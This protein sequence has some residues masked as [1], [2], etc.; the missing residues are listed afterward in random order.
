MSAQKISLRLCWML[1]LL[2]ILCFAGSDSYGQQATIFQKLLN[3]ASNEIVEGK[4]C[5]VSDASV[6]NAE[7]RAKMEAD[8]P[9]KN[10]VSLKINESSTRYF[11]DS[12]T[13]KVLVRIVSKDANGLIDSVDKEFKVNYQLKDK[14]QSVSSYITEGKR[15]VTARILSVTAPSATWVLYVIQLENKMEIRPLF[16]FSYDNDVVTTL[17]YPASLTGAVDQL[18]VT[19]PAVTGIDVYDVEWTYV[20]SSA[21]ALKKKNNA[22]DADLIFTNNASRVTVSATSYKIPLLY[23]GKGMLFFRVRPVQL[24]A[25]SGRLEGKWSSTDTK[26]LGAFAFEGHETG[27]NWQATTSFAEEGKRKTVVQYFDGSLRSRQVVTKDNTSDTTIIGE[28]FYD[29]QGRAVIQVLP[30]PSLDRVI[31]FTR[32]FNMGLNGEYDKDKYDLLTSP[33]Y[34]CNAKAEPMAKTSGSSRYYSPD[35]AAKNQGNNKFLPDASLYPFSQ[36]EY[37]PDNTGKISRQGGVGPDYQLGSGHETK[38]YYGGSPDKNELYALFGTDVGDAAHYV[39]NMVRD[40]NGQY[41]ISYLDMRGHVIATALAGNVPDS[42]KLQPLI[43][44]VSE[45]AVETIGGPSG[46]TIKGLSMES[47]KVLHVT[48]PGSYNFSYKLDPDTLRMLNYDQSASCY[49]CLYDLEITITDDCNNQKL[50]GAPFKRIR[51]NFSLENNQGLNA[52]CSKGAEKFIEEF[53][54]NLDEGSYVVT[55]KL[56]VSQYALDYYR[57]SVFVKK[58]AFKTIEELAKEERTLQITGECIPDC[59]SC[60]QQLGEWNDFRAS[61]LQKAGVELSDTAAHRGEAWVAWKEA[62][63]RC[64]RLC[65]VITEAD[66]LHNAMVADMTP[67]SGQYA[68]IN[69]IDDPYSIFYIDTIAQT[70]PIYKN[71]ALYYT[72]QEGSADKVYDEESETWVTPHDLNV[73]QFAAKFNK[74]WAETLL[75]YHPEYCKLL[76]YEKNRASLAWN[77]KAET[78]DTYQEAFDSGYLNPSGYIS[79]E[80]SRFPIVDK[81]RDPLSDALKVKVNSKIAAYMKDNEGYNISLW[82]MATIAVMANADKDNA[83]KKYRSPGSAFDASMCAGD[84]DM[85]WRIYRQ[86]Y[87]QLKNDYIQQMLID[88]NC[89]GKPAAKDLSDKGYTVH[90]NTAA[91]ALS[92]SGMGDLLSTNNP[93]QSATVLKAA[94]AQEYENNCRAYASM[95]MRQM[96]PCSRYDQVRTEIIEELVKVC[97]KGADQNHTMGSRNI[98]P[99]S[100]NTY[101]SFEDV[102]KEYN[103]RL[104]IAEGDLQ[105]NADVFTAPMPFDK[106]GAYSQ[107]SYTRPDECVRAKLANYQYQYNQNKKVGESFSTYLARTT[108]TYISDVDLTTFIDICNN[109]ASTC[110]YAEKTVSIPPVFQCYTGDVC[111]PCEKVNDLYTLFTAKYPAITPVIGVEVDSIQDVKNRLFENFMNSRLGFSKQAWEY[112]QFM[113][114]CKGGDLDFGVVKRFTI[115]GSK[116][117]VIKSVFTTDDNAFIMAG[118]T[119]SPADDMNAF[120]AKTDKNGKVLWAKDYGGTGK[121]YFSKVIKGVDGGLAAIGTTSSFN[122]GGWA[123]SSSGTVRSATEAW[124]VKLDENGDVVW[125]KTMSY[126]STGEK[127]VDITTVK[128]TDEDGYAIVGEYQSADTIGNTLVARLK[129]N[130]DPIWIKQ[131][132]SNFSDYGGRIAQDGDTI[133]VAASSIKANPYWFLGNNSMVALYRFLTSNGD[134][135]GFSIYD[136][137]NINSTLRSLDVMPNGYRITSLN[138]ID[139]VHK[140]NRPG[141]S[142]LKVDKTGYFKSVESYGRY[143][144]DDET[145]SEFSATVLPNKDL[146]IVKSTSM[147]SNDLRFQTLTSTGRDYSKSLNI[148]GNEVSGY[149]LQN[150]D[151]SFALVGNSTTPAA[152]P[153]FVRLDDSFHAACLDSTVY[154]GY[155]GTFVG[156]NQFATP[157]V[158]AMLTGGMRTISVIANNRSVGESLAYC[159]NAKSESRMLCGRSE[160]VFPEAVIPQYTNCTDSTF[161]AVNVA[162]ERY[163]IIRD[164][165]Y[166]KFD[167]AYLAKCMTAIQYEDF[168]V[169]HNANEYHYTLYYYDQ[170][171]NLVQTIAPNDVKPNRDPAWLKEVHRL[172]ETNGAAKRPDHVK[173][174]RYRYNSLN[175]VVAQ[176]SPDAGSSRFWYDRLGR[177]TL[178]Q[179]AEQI[180]YNKYSYT[181]YDAIGRITEVGQLASAELMNDN[182]SR[183]DVELKGWLTRSANSREQVTRTVY[184]LPYIPTEYDFKP[185]NLR[186]RVS[187]SAVYDTYADLTTNSYNNATYYSYDVHGNVDTLLQNYNNDLMKG[188]AS[189]FKKI[190][191]RYDLVSGKVNHVAYQ[192]GQIDAFY[193]RYSYDAENRLVNVETSRDSVNWDND[194]RYSYYSHGPLSRVVLGQQQVQG[195]D[196]AY[197]LQGWIKAVNPGL[198]LTGGNGETCSDGSA[199]NDLI[200]NARVPNGP[201]VYKARVTISFEDGFDSNSEDMDALIDANATLCNS[202]ATNLI[203]TDGTSTTTPAKDEFS[204]V[205]HYN[206]TDYKPLVAGL[207][208]LTVPGQLGDEYRPLYNGNISGMGV[209]VSKLDKPLWYNYKYDQLN[210][211]VQMDAWKSASGNWNTL[212]KGRSNNVEN[213][214]HEGITYDAN[215]N[216]ISYDRNGFAKATGVPAMDRLAYHYV[217]GKNRLDHIDD[218]APDTAYTTDIEGQ[219]AGYYTYDSIGNLTHEGGS[220]ITWNVYGKIVS[221]KKEDNVLIRYSYD[222]FGNRICKAVGN[223]VTWYVRDIRGNVLSIYQSGESSVNSGNLSQTEVHL[224]GTGRLG[225]LKLDNDMT[226]SWQKKLDLIDNPTFVRGN[227]LFELSNHLG[228]ILAAVSDK[229]LGITSNNSFADSYVA[230]V[231]SAQ[232]YYPFGMIMPGRNYNAAV[233]R[234]GFNGKENDNEIKGDGNQQDYGMRIYDPRLGRF[235]SVDPL[236]SKYPELTPYQFASNTPLQAVDLDGA[237]ALFVHGTFSDKSTFDSRFV[238]NMLHATGW[239]KVQKNAYFGNWSGA[240]KS[241]ARIEAANAFFNFLTSDKN[242]YRDLK[243]ATLIGHSHGGNVNKVLRNMLIKAGWTVDIINIET[244]QRTDFRSDAGH[245]GVYLSF[246]NS[247]DVVQFAGAFG[248]RFNSGS[249]KDPSADA[250]VN[251][252][253]FM[254]QLLAPDDFFPKPFGQWLKDSGGHGLHNNDLSKIVIELRTQQAFDAYKKL[255]P[256][257]IDTK[258]KSSYMKYLRKVF[259]DKM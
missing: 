119:V 220:A 148:P 53:S 196:Y 34:Y 103:R 7:T 26:G 43:S 3:G 115:A 45:D 86:L 150:A 203:S 156:I 198:L 40:A 221:I 80:F 235:L 258:G 59:E 12:F 128:G 14:Y 82:N 222:A 83:A 46:N 49:D 256:G 171:G 67:P 153:F 70:L 166:G 160:P 151:G 202:S 175:Q 236:M 105:C 136:I 63:D 229:K 188:G 41:S 97:R 96:A 91:A 244:P 100:T 54:L 195:I 25:R 187:F 39:K 250:N 185:A 182:K 21:L 246:Y 62:N 27:L 213:E 48:E 192:P 32:D 214:Y 232:D 217:P 173:A 139:S 208:D 108:G 233:Y 60:K 122:Q 10:I 230:D 197:T 44:N 167:S 64:N 204:Y 170:A 68:N 126:T 254:P 98:S 61:Y 137:G 189:Q 94:M 13:V 169:A 194:A 16:K 76:E 33:D 255:Y 140:T 18:P 174:T 239:D 8:Y 143:W 56:S 154:S 163:K 104:G 241:E 224:Y 259:N 123:R 113:D 218:S 73:T 29:Y 159:E 74:S 237:E 9:V 118:Y 234:Y 129:S 71:T 248:N 120:V 240:N 99:D 50:G 125:S 186:N 72:N 17:S 52:D 227:K 117:T 135:A 152:Q 178:S 6:F 11:Q 211:L 155:M 207:S 15:E 36:T 184:D 179:N 102:I 116:E 147:V 141:L 124:L 132:G 121:D 81:N 206:K 112:L 165:L 92:Q 23:D 172:V 109:Q 144:S 57:D 38:Y 28:S 193:H 161:Y 149:M 176:N 138:T 226:L 177:L 247:L 145:P 257:G 88:A 77:I 66:E 212:T 130:G 2:V 106:Q 87:I 168:T 158:D 200:V 4:T 243:H 231:V 75:P 199:V 252:P 55:K 205:L 95:W 164:S 223:K 107:V 89:A 79:S 210:R 146:I 245:G 37:T 19:W 181:L 110:T 201:P 1:L 216:I 242:P 114:S 24:K 131:V 65:E 78:I 69:N 190:V 249:R 251:L 215:G 225:V 127:G 219:S 253:E 5:S 191:Y 47:Q 30:T 101:A 42:I 93:T 84:K 228:N 142:I 22:W 20:D 133:V 180:R 134:G 35:N 51:R 162:T 90:F 111:V 157:R 183:N 58:N 209:N 31:R 85:A 238:K